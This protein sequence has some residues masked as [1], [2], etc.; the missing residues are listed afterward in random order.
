[1]M[2]WVRGKC[3]QAVLVSLSALAATPIWAGP[4]TSGGGEILEQAQNPW[5]L[6]GP[7]ATAPIH[8][9]VE[10]AADFPVPLSKLAILTE[11]AFLWWNNQFGNAFDPGNSLV[12]QGA[13]RELHV[14]VNTSRFVR[15]ESCSAGTD[16]AFQFGNLNNDQQTEFQRLQIELSR[17][18]AL[19]IRTDYSD[20]LRGK[21]FIYVSPDR[22]PNA[23]HGQNVRPEAWTADDPTTSRL[24]AVLIHELGHV[25]GLAHAQS[26]DSI[27]SARLAE[28]LVSTISNASM[29]Y[30]TAVQGAVFFPKAGG[31]APEI[32]GRLANTKVFRDYF[33][34]PDDMDCFRVQLNLNSLVIQAKAS[35]AAPTW[36]RIGMARFQDGGQR[37]HQQLV[38][39]WLPPTQKIFPDLPRYIT[40]LLG[41]AASEVQ[42]TA[43]FVIDRTGE[44]RM[45]FV[46]MA[47]RYVQIGGVTAK[48]IVPDLLSEDAY[49]HAL[50]GWS[51]R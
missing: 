35:S 28:M 20:E 27:M 33:A 38:T 22:G 24:Q 17:Y 31:T 51:E 34:I 15:E 14:L 3:V 48:G 50:S 41:P 11:R 13:K 37:R 6:D 16:L 49:G 18:V 39:L 36:Q 46:Q 19:T 42:N 12:V 1:M 32:C 30:L 9:C 45:I 5:F 43:T 23:F 47:P 25:F 2:R 7:R 4:W 21:G 29:S 8:Y 26:N 10:A 40:S 44:S